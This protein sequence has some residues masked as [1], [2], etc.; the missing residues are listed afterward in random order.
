[1]NVSSSNTCV[2]LLFFYPWLPQ[3]LEQ[4]QLLPEDEG[5]MSGVF[6][7]QSASGAGTARWTQLEQEKATHARRLAEVH[8][9]I[10]ADLAANNEDLKAEI[11]KAQCKLATSPHSLPPYIYVLPGCPIIK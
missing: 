7:V 4:E 3:H 9:Q 11:G 2:D 6:C 1:M 8:S 5:G 10:I